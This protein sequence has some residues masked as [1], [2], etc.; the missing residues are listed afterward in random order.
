M[1][2]NRIKSLELNYKILEDKLNKVVNQFDDTIKKVDKVKTK[3]YRELSCE[4]CIITIRTKHELKAH[5]NKMHK[6]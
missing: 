1:L 5:K 4:I 2:A 6:K 3:T